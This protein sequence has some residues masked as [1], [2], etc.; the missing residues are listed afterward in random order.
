MLL[1][2]TFTDGMA[3][4][5]ENLPLNETMF[6]SVHPGA[7]VDF[8]PGYG[9]RAGFRFYRCNTGKLLAV[10]FWCPDIKDSK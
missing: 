2:K 1:H 6:R 3:G 5:I 9:L 7:Y 8:A 10:R 4:E